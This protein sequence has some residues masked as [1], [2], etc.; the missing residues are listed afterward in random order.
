MESNSK[1]QWKLETGKD[2]A[3]ALHW[4]RQRTEG[5]LLLALAFG[6]NKISFA[7]HP[8]LRSSDAIRIIQEELENLKHSL[9]RIDAEG[10]QKGSINRRND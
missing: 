5:R 1:K 2:V 7:K 8:D 4:I 3:D 6:K 10:Q 9:E